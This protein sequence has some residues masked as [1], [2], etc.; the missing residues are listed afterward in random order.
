MDHIIYV[1]DGDNRNNGICNMPSYM[2][3][4]NTKCIIMCNVCMYV[5]VYTYM[6]ICVKHKYIFGIR[7]RHQ[8]YQR[9]SSSKHVVPA[10]GSGARARGAYTHTHA[11]YKSMNVVIALYM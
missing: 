1:Y 9:T 6:Y 8:T 4:Y 7:R 5:H 3:V 10:A 11:R 2:Y